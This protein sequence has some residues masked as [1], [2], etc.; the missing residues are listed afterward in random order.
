MR[1]SVRDVMTKVAARFDLTLAE[2]RSPT[3]VR[4]IARPRQMA[5][6]LACLHTEKSLPQI[7]F[8]FD[9]DHSTVVAARKRIEALL[10]EDDAL[11]ADI[12]TLNLEFEQG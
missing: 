5:M 1:V 7:G 4:H 12:E 6:Y 3:R 9:R 11:A 10:A 8:C 2:L